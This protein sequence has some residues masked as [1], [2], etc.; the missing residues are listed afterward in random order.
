VSAVLRALKDERWSVV[1]FGTA[2]FAV[3]FLQAVAFH[4][5]AGATEAGRKAFGYALSL[6]ATANAA[7]FPT[8]PHLDTVGGYLELRAFAPLAILFAAW[9]LVSATGR[10]SP[11]IVA[12]AAGFA[13]AVTIAAAAAC[14]GVLVGAAS[15]GE[16]VG[17][18]GVLEAGLLLAALASACFGICIATA[19]LSPAATLIAGA[20]LLAI[21]FLDSLSR[22]FE[23]LAAP[24]WLSPFRYYELSDVAG[25]AALIAI[26]VAGTA[27]AVVLSRRQ[28]R[29]ATT[30]GS[31]T[32][33]PSRAP[34][35]GWPV[36]RIL[37]P[38]RFAYAAWCVGFAILGI[39]LVAAARAS[40]QDI[41]ALPRLLPGL[42]QYLF[43]LYAE[44][45]GQTWFQVVLLLL[46]AL[47]FV[48]V[49][50]WSAQDRDGRL[51]AQLSEPYSRSAVVLERV[52]AVA[53]AAGS[54]AV[55][56]GVGVALTSVAADLTLD[57]GHVA[58]ASVLLVVFS[59]VL[60]AAGSLLTS[61]IPRAAP[62]LFGGLVLASFLDDQIGGALG[63]PG[64]LQ[65]VSPFR[66]VGAP[67]AAGVDV[68]NLVLM[69]LLAAAA[70][71][72]SILLMQRRDVAT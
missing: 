63:L 3:A 9:A 8:P 44:V 45:L 71:G 6:Q 39:V 24:A 27:L 50:S 38:E 31:P 17:V 69:L 37:Y 14:L 59:V 66:L 7:L 72:T 30:P 46:V 18:G 62:T 41:L 25:F 32:F 65:T 16:N 64:W 53:V 11:H 2:G 26:A 55:L 42:P 5:L 54:L 21:Y 49:A 60:G 1:G 58:G 48:F 40:M 51:E 19:Q 61:W 15:A 70:V 4:R 13:I 68:R 57:M 52:G 35:L 36:I 22:I 20:L 28:A 12:R 23:Q 47:V 33:E 56:S 43:V 67:L 10:G 34:L 29:S